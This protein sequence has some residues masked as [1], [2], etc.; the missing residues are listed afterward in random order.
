MQ[1]QLSIPQKS[2]EEVL[3]KAIHSL[4]GEQVKIYASGRT[5][6][7]VHALGQVVHFDLGKK[8]NDYQLTSGLNNY[9]REE[10]VSVLSCELVDENF[11]ARFSAKT[12]HYR[13]RII[14]RRAPLVLTKNHAWHVSRKLD[15]EAMR[16]AT[17]HLIGSHNFSSF[18]DAQCQAKSPVRT[19]DKIAITQRDDELH[20]EFS[21]KSFLHHMVRNIMGTLVY[22]GLG[23]ISAAQVK[24]ILE[25]HDRTKSG[26][27]A[28]AYGLYFLQT[29]Y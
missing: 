17:Q 28:P 14:N 10:A 11:H 1:K 2:V 26:P 22:V 25:A 12:R 29:H 7:G 5:D 8:F 27:N 16:Q 18:R 4:S 21:A 23:K 15:V 6:A 19:L 24:E 9:L 13:Y 20:F 3:E